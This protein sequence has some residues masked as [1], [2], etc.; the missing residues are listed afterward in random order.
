MGREKSENNLGRTMSKIQLARDLEGKSKEEIIRDFIDLYEKYEKL[1]RKLRKYENPHTPPSKDERKTNVKTRNNFVSKTGL[2]VGKQTGYK[3]KTRKKKKPTHFI[4]NFEGIC[5]KCGKL[6][7]PKRIKKKIYEETPEPQPIK[8]IEATWGEYE[9][10]CGH[11]WESKH[12]DTPEKGLF[13]KNA[14]THITL[15][16][17]D[18][19]LPLRK[20]VNALGRHYNLELTS[21][22][23]YDITKRVAEKATPQYKEIQRKIRRAKS[24]HIDE[25]KIKIQGKLYYVWI[26]RSSKFIFF[27]IRKERNRNVLDEILG[28]NYQGA[29][30]CD[31]LSAYKEYTKFL[32]RCWAHILRETRELAEKY[33]DA[34]P[35]HNWMTELFGKVKSASVKDSLVKRKEK[36]DK[37]IQEMKRLISI[38]SSY[39]HL[40]KVITT[41]ENGL[42]FWFTRILHPRIE[43][44]NNKAEQPLREIKVIQKIIGTLRNEDG[45]SIMETIMTLLATWR[46]QRKNPFNEL[47]ALV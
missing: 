42:E 22:A 4:N 36:Y 18:D 31:G 28:Y 44:T 46:L 26:F 43:P 40:K 41:I 5:A 12:K 9:C 2:S 6:N 3:G 34:K 21:K 25:T 20:T 8:V 16:K 47:R 45:A 37:C 13:G 27:V 39:T 15:L 30:I 23:V 32:Q 24:L 11:C 10:N 29:I 17:F 19:R 14:Q 33:D 35:M 1:E 38:Y 7:K